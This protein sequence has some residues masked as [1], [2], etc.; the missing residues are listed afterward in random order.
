MRL[1]TVTTIAITI[2]IIIV[3]ITIIMTHDHHYQGYR[4]HYPLVNQHSYGKK[5]TLFMGTHEILMAMA[6]LNSYVSH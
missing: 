2:I 5:T 3:I 6:M 4:L 1:V